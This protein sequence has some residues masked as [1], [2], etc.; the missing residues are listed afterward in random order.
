MFVARDQEPEEKTLP[1]A[2]DARIVLDGSEGKLSDLKGADD[3]P[4]AM[5]RLSLD[6]KVVQ[7]IYIARGRN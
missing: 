2:Q 7:G 5:L 1:V 4:L 3:G 6:Q